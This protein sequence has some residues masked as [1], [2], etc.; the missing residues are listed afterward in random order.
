MWTTLAFVA[1][2]TLTSGQSDQLALTNV[3]TTYG[4]LGPERPDNKFLPGDSLVLSFDIEGATVDA[5]GKLLYSIGME[6]TDHDGKALFRQ[7][8]RSLEAK[9]G[10][11]S[12]SVPG[13]ANLQI[14]LDQ[15][16]GDYTLK[17]TVTDRATKASREVT[18]SYQVLP[19][20]F[21]LVRLAL[22]GD[23]GRAAEDLVELG[24][25]LGVLQRV[26]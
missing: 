2:L 18:R 26:A 7:E 15:P 9:V 6:V 17:V 11:A 21:G 3:R 5:G 20:A 23:P 24:R 8:P 25:K 19:K 1:A 10:P 14:G 12:K 4:A 13:R 16:A 22:S